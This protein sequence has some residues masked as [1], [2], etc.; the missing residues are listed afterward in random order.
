MWTACTP[1]SHSITTKVN[2]LRITLKKPTFIAFCKVL[3]GNAK[4]QILLISWHFLVFLCMRPLTRPHINTLIFWQMKGVEVIHIWT[5]FRLSL[6][7]S[8]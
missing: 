2:M 3:L 7:C 5:K 8:S 4:V 1:S 6:L